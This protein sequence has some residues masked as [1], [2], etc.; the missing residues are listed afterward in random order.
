MKILMTLFDIQDYGGIINHAE[1]LA[2]GFVKLG[3]TVDFVKLC[4]KKKFGVTRGPKPEVLAEYRKHGTGLFFHQARGWWWPN[5]NKVAY[6]DPNER[7]KFKNK[8]SGYDFVLWHIP[9]P[10][11]N[12]E[13]AA[14]NEW[15]DLYNSG[16]KNI[17]IVHDGNLPELYPHL[18]WVGHHF[19]AMVCVHESAYHSAECIAIP[20]KMIVNPFDLTNAVPMSKFETRA[21]FCAV[22]VFKAW[23]RVD[24]L[25][26]AIPHLKTKE[27]KRIG[28]AGIEYRYMTSQDKCKP[29]YFDAAGDRIW[30]KALRYGME[31]V[32]TIPTDMHYHILRDSKLQIDPSW[33]KK[34]SAFGAHFNRTTMEAMICGAVPVATDLGM[35]NSEV[36]KAGVNY[37]EVPAAATPQEFADIIDNGLTDNNQWTTIANNNVT[38]IQR[39]AH[40]TVAQ[41]YIDLANS[42]Q[43]CATGKETKQLQEKCHKKLEFFGIWQATMGAQQ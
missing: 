26:R 22:Q 30:D 7:A 20:R 43:G 17:A 13:N 4:P 2:A 6:L 28:G 35:N 3:H 21:G 42:T 8:C 29:K 40:T 34:Y 19:H 24:T 1:N 36:F 18:A 14:V 33:S 37:I 39:F 5:E 11:V 23:K 15:V 27:P 41:E 16:T 10:T 32:G 38:A 12:K 31:Y 25:I 9:V